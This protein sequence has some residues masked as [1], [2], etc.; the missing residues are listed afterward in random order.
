[1]IRMDR[2]FGTWVRREGIRSQN[3]GR[4]G[5]APWNPMV[6][7]VLNA[8]EVVVREPVSS[9]KMLRFDRSF[10]VPHHHI[11]DGDCAAQNGQGN[12]QHQRRKTLD[13][14]CSIHQHPI[15]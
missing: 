9:R 1:M 3:R 13:R 2:R 11:E 4:R 7:L 10:P 6:C 14:G 12:D 8:D 15:T 5:I